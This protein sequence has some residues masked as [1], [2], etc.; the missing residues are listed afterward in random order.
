MVVVEVSEDHV[1]NP[2]AVD[3]K[4][5]QSLGGAAQVLPSAARR[6][7]GGEARIYDYR[8]LGGHRGP[9]EIVHRHGYVV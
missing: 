7:L 1:G 9:H 2:R 4:S 3:A 8:V 6:Y 5:L